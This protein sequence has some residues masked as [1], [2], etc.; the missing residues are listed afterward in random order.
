MPRRDSGLRAEIAELVGMLR[1]YFVQE[2][3]GP[4]RGLGRYV[5]FGLIGAVGVSLGVV[6]AALALVRVLQTETSV[7]NAN[8]S[9]VPHLAGAA[10]LLLAIAALIRAIRPR[11]TR[12]EHDS[13]TAPERD[14][15][16]SVNDA[17]G[18]EDD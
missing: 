14:S 3:V 7:F 11:H 5:L 10:F 8:W 16:E 17:A 18:D 15:R 1:S 12:A 13:A 2:T 4:L 6:F 9:F